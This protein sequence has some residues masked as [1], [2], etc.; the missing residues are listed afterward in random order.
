MS[1]VVGGMLMKKER[2]TPQI[3]ANWFANKRKD[4][5]RRVGGMSKDYGRNSF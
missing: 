4:I 3:V 1:A 2:V 5:K